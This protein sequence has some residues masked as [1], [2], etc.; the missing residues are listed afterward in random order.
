MTFVYAQEEKDAYT[1]IDEKTG[2]TVVKL[3]KVVYTEGTIPKGEN[4]TLVL[5][6]FTK[7]YVKLSEGSKLDFNVYGD[8]IQDLVA[9]NSLI[10]QKVNK[11]SADFL[12]SQEGS[13]YKQLKFYPGE[14]SQMRLNFTGKIPFM[15][16][17]I[18]KWRFSDDGN[19][20]VTL[21]F[22][23][24][25]VKAK[26]QIEPQ[27]ETI[28]TTKVNSGIDNKNKYWPYYIGGAV[29]LLI[30]LILIFKPKFKKN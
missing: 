29:V 6:Y 9:Q 23:I 2:E 22:N 5:T 3:P 24:P 30:A 12:F 7:S 26:Q 25:V 4:G 16:V 28:D 20:H 18:T 17:E 13:E 11:D 1:Y 27:K 15:F 8:N 19:N 10:L 14:E 21:F